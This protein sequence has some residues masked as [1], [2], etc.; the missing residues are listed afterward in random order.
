MLALH[1][2]PMAGALFTRYDAISIARGG[3]MKTRSKAANKPAK[4][5][6][7]KASKPKGRSAPKPVSGRGVAP[8]RETEVARL[9][10]ERDEALE[11][12]TATADVLK[13]IS[14]STFDLQL[15]LE[16]LLRSAAQ[17]CAADKGGVWQ[18]D[19]ELFRATA[20]YGL[21]HEAH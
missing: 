6:P 5:H 15:V 14:R 2:P 10:R 1:F 9:T 19:G 3:G 12:Q 21:T 18:R 17:L 8:A 11:Q 13:V 4:A 16:T 7:R 20:T